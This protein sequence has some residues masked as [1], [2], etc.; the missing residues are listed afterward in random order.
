MLG[1]GPG[2][3]CDVSC[4]FAQDSCSSLPRIPCRLCRVQSG[5]TTMDHSDLLPGLWVDKS[6][7]RL[8]QEKLFFGGKKKNVINQSA[9]AAWTDKK[10]WK[11]HHSSAAGQ[12]QQDGGKN[13]TK[14]SCT[15]LR[16]QGKKWWTILSF[17]ACFLA[18]KRL[19]TQSIQQQL[20]DKQPSFITT[21]I[22]MI[23][24][25]ILSL[26]NVKNQKRTINL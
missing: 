9:G 8:Q 18:R 12:Q 10:E 6:K 16:V 22:L 20:L 26:V 21:L 24:L 23:L 11:N 1:S 13:Y 15:H 14:S 7:G 4:L 17:S 3:G 2:N 25:V 5:W 19:P